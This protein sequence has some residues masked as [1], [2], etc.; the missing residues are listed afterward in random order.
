[1]SWFVATEDFISTNWQVADLCRQFELVSN[2]KRFACV[3]AT[4]FLAINNLYFPVFGQSFHNYSQSLVDALGKAQ[5]AAD[6]GKLTEAKAQYEQIINLDG[7]CPE[8]FA[9]LGHVYLLL[10]RYSDAEKPLQAA[11]KIQPTNATIYNGLGHAA[12]RQEHYSQAIDNFKKALQY[13]KDDTYKIHVNLANALSDSHQVDEAEKHFTKAIELKPD[14]APAYNGLAMMHYNSQHFEEAV[15][16]AKKAIEL[17]PD[18]AMGWYNLGIALYQL[19]RNSE[20]KNALRNSLKYEHSKA[21]IADTKRILAEMENSASKIQ[22][23]IDSPQIDPREI[24]RM[25]RERKWQA[26]AG[27]IDKELKAGAASSSTLWNNL[28]YALM[29][30]R[31]KYRQARSALEKAITLDNGHNSTAHY[32]LGQLL[33]LMNDSRGAELAFR[34]SIDDSKLTRTPCALAQNAL[35]LML[36]QRNDFVGAEAC[37]KRALMDDDGALPVV[38]YNR[39]IVLERLDNSREA[40]NEY[41]AYLAHAP[42]GLNAKQAQLRLKMLGIDPS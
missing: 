16:N 40:V 17:K 38:H 3:L 8:A 23:N 30:E 42:N 4:A 18:Y 15:Q 32:N 34:K 28:G 41:K 25:L 13:A 9:G 31:G 2:C 24:E 37:Y 33:R 19:K 14:Y 39:A 20:A 11:L 26:A 29:H 21:Y 1:M 36:K 6:Q 22:P 10:G 12:Y 27:A 35:G 5:I 7:G